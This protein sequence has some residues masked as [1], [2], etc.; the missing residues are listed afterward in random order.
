MLPKSKHRNILINP[1]RCL[2]SKK[3]IDVDVKCSEVLKFV[4]PFLENIKKFSQTD[5]NMVSCGLSSAYPNHEMIPKER[6]EVLMD[7]TQV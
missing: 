6:I 7:K 4:E 3:R 5:M 2:F 1:S